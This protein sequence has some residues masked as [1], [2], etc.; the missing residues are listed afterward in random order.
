MT[1]VV[2]VGRSPKAVVP[3]GRAHPVSCRTDT[4]MDRLSV[5]CCMSLG[6]HLQAVDTSARSSALK[7]FAFS[8]WTTES[9]V[10]VD[11]G[12]NSSCVRLMIES[13]TCWCL[14]KNNSLCSF[15]LLVHN[16]MQQISSW[17]TNGS[18]TFSKNF[19]NFFFFFNLKVQCHRR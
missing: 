15:Y 8:G 2:E 18:S 3:I 12:L 16:N 1:S 7:Q 11:R 6:L 10:T 19:A 14:Y 5:L 13:D 17:E 9:P 4:V